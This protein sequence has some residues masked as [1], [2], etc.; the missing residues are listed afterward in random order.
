VLLVSLPFTKHWQVRTTSSSCRWFLHTS[1]QAAHMLPL[2]ALDTSCLKKAL[3][4]T[5][6]TSSLLTG[7][8]PS[9]H[10]CL[11]VHSHPQLPLSLTLIQAAAAGTRVGGA[12]KGSLGAAAAAGMPPAVAA[13]AAGGGCAD[14]VCSPAVVLM[15]AVVCSLFFSCCIAGAEVSRST[16]LLHEQQLGRTGTRWA[17]PAGSPSL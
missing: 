3:Q 5:A 14:F 12:W 13:A 16:R 7:T 10:H 8:Y 9:P 11:I 15:L 1:I 17:V 2:Q 6:H 4:N